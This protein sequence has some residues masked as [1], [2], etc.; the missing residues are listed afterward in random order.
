VE[1]QGNEFC[2]L[3]PPIAQQQEKAQL[4]YEITNQVVR[5]AR[6]A[7]SSGSPAPSGT[8]TAENPPPDGRCELVLR[9]SG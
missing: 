8:M 3:L 6:Q 2:W 7:P 1:E 5:V 9:N 4:Q